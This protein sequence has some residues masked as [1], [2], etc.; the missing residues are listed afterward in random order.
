MRRSFGSRI[1][2]ISANKYMRWDKFGRL[3]DCHR[4]WGNPAIAELCFPFANCALK[5]AQNVVI[6]AV[7]ADF[8][9]IFEQ[10]VGGSLVTPQNQAQSLRVGVW[11]GFRRIESRQ[12]FTVRFR[13]VVYSG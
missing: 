6:A 3:L 10:N 9:K 8:D 2:R 4:P 7:P 12:Y 11:V 13:D 5:T 1:V